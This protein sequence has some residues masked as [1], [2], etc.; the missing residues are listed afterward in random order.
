LI[1][2]NMNM[3]DK[4]S[5]SSSPM[6]PYIHRSVVRLP[7]VEP[8]TPSQAR[9]T[10]SSN[11]LKMTR[12]LVLETASTENP[13]LLKLNKYMEEQGQKYGKSL[14]AWEELAASASAKANQESSSNYFSGSHSDMNT[15]IRTVER[16]KHKFFTFQSP[17]NRELEESDSHQAKPSSEYFIK[18]SRPQSRPQFST[19]K[20]KW[21]SLQQVANDQSPSSIDKASS[22]THRKKA[23]IIKLNGY[24]SPTS[25]SFSHLQT[26]HERTFN[27]EPVSSPSIGSK[28]SFDNKLESIRS[29]KSLN[30]KSLM[31]QDS[32]PVKPQKFLGGVYPS[33]PS[34]NTRKIIITSKNSSPSKRTLGNNVM[35]H[36]LLLESTNKQALK[37]VENVNQS[38]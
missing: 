20:D 11:Q 36:S 21:E 37:V 19:L 10:R 23:N 25:P 7:N 12:K 35:A 31:R 38:S 14:V 13:H 26:V 3:K 22:N 4:N 32:T 30:E 34:K 16:R 29:P 17:K 8:T 9:R 28:N 5:G 18:E 15:P 33:P 27:E 6:S 2:K 1:D 24:N